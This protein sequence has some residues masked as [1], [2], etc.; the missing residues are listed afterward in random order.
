VLAVAGEAGIGKSRILTELAVEAGRRGASVLLGRAYE[1]ERILPFGPWVVAVRDAG[2]L[3]DA[4]M[5][6]LGNVWRAELAR[7]FPELAETSDTQPVEPADLHRV[8]E[9]LAEL[10]RHVALA[11]PVVILLEDCHWADDATLRFLG[12]FA[13][14]IRSAPILLALSVREEEIDDTPILRLT[15][16]ELARERRLT[17]LTLARLPREET[18][19]LVQ[20]LGRAG[21][22][23]ETV[24]Q[25]GEQ[26]WAASAGNPFVVIETMRAI[27]SDVVL[28]SGS[29]G[30]LP[31]PA[32]VGEMI[33]RR[34]DRL[35]ERA[36]QLVRV[37]AV[38]GS[39]FEFA[40]LQRAAGLSEPEAAEGVEEL[41]RRR[42]LHGVGDS[43]DFTHERI[44]DVVVAELLVPRRH[45]LHAAVAHALE[46]LVT[47]DVLR[48]TVALGTHYREAG[49][50]EKAV[51]AFRQAGRQAT[52]RCAYREAAA[53]LEQARSAL[54]SLPESRATLEG[55][56]DI[57]MELRNAL[58]PLGEFP[59]IIDHMR[60]AGS[61]ALRLGD[62]SRRV[63]AAAFLVDQLRIAGEHE[64]AL[65]EGLGALTLAESADDPSLTVLIAT[66]VA[67]VHHLR[68]DYR[69]AVALFKRSLE[70]PGV[71]ASERLGLLQPP[72]VH[73]R[74][75]LVLSLGE[76]GAFAEGHTAADECLA[77][78]T[79]IDQSVALGFAWA[80][81]GYLALHER[82]ASRAIEAFARALAFF[83]RGAA[84]PWVSRVTAALGYGFALSGRAVQALQLLGD[85]L[86]QAA[87]IGMN[88]ARP[89]LLAWAAEARV[90]MGDAPAAVDTAAAALTLAK[91]QGERGHAAWALRARAE[92]EAQLGTGELERAAQS[93]REA[94]SLSSE[95]DMLPLVAHCRFGLG[96]LYVRAGAR[97]R[98][99]VELATAETL[100][101][102]LAMEPCR[103]R[104]ARALGELTSS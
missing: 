22:R 15:L 26:V 44:R 91:Q 37:A 82:D 28:A 78:A 68:G 2:I 7:V 51:V 102:A 47:N 61:L 87:A 34:L 40:L 60:E 101:A 45:L 11:Q 103:A 12:F 65:D 13:R 89:L 100:F 16:D 4:Q 104:A 19:T 85:A 58:L 80:A 62:T 32:S 88:A 8:F 6:G 42:I 10:L 98:A 70:Q 77:I 52:E 86:D 95:L 20:R 66:R 29:S 17:W 46:D 73:S 76:V 90:A 23:D 59:T 63:R 79:A 48:H 72:A 25:R 53:L 36:R 69:S 1:S 21:A 30:R 9:A 84:S 3:S 43:F 5:E 49:I 99:R 35:S 93:Y 97:A 75:S 54:T 74:Y 64:R 24:A 33:V 83:A 14:R 92:A 50:W 57:R 55:A 27:A 31:L 56:F 94:L 67:Q 96:N 18:L 81:F 41:V 71:P 39:E 38:I